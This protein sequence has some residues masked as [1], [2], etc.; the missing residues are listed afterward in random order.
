ME[1][2]KHPAG[3]K[4]IL[5]FAWTVLVFYACASNAGKGGITAE[6]ALQ[7]VS[8]YCHSAYDWSIAKDNPDIMGIEM[9][10][11]TDSTYQVIFRSYTGALEYFYVSKAD[12]TARIV[13]S[14]PALGIESEAGTIDLADYFK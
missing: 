11:E 2:K 9:G 12:G 5:P 8:N 4:H 1:T 3:L 13:E 6:K 10:E 14:V 7:G